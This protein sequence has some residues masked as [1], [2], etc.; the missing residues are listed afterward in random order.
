[1]NVLVIN[2]SPKGKYSVT[3][4]SCLFLEKRFPDINFEYI[5]PAYSIEAFE[6]RFSFVKD[7]I[8]RAELIIF[9][10]PVYTFLVPAQLHKFIEMVKERGIDFSGK[11]VTQITTSKHFYDV[12]AHKFIEENC[13][14][15]GMK[16]IKGLSQDQEELLEQKG[17]EDLIMFFRYVLHCIDNDVYEVN[18][19]KAEAPNLVM[20]TAVENKPKKTKK[21]IALV[22]DLAKGDALLASMLNRFILRVPYDLELVNLHDFN[23]I[24]GC[25]S[26]LNCAENGECLFND[27]FSEMLRDQIQTCDAVVL[28][29]TLRD[30]SMGSIF[31][32]YDDRQFCNGHRSV[33][34]GKPFGYLVSG[35]L[36][37]EDNLRTVIE[38][39]AEV[40]GNFLA[41]I[42]T[43]EFNPDE[44]I[45]NMVDRLLFALEHS[46]SQPVNFYGVGGKKIFRDLVWLMQGFMKADHKFFM[47]ND[48][49]DFPQNDK[50][51][52]VK[53]K[54]VGS[55][56][57][58]P[59]TKRRM[60]SSLNELII[61][62]YKKII[63][64]M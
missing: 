53:M 18:Y 19:K 55:L 58:N 46:Y 13:N 27:G 30:H 35:A 51:T 54:A 23:F 57:S 32:T 41:G 50:K 17:Q 5:Y 37:N 47:E 49:Y 28:G 25:I 56:L 61:E 45:D 22:Y 62:P 34:M 60:G 4:Q 48:L 15:L 2:G 64:E 63:D 6:K 26:C 36:S 42:A 3:L 24:N 59:N 16:Y 11:Y 7:A 12:T 43:N 20:A 38:A 33:T 52:M 21:R 1:M 40:G 31:K 29:F 14:D 8:E 9:S 44:E 39:R 10:Y